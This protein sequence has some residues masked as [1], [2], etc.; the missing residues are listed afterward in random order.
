MQVY[1]QREALSAQKSYRGVDDQDRLDFIRAQKAKLG[2]GLERVLAKS[3]KRMPTNHF[4][5]DDYDYLEFTEIV[6]QRDIAPGTMQPSD[7]QWSIDEFTK[8]M[9]ENQANTMDRIKA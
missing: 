3:N 2:P 8:K 9:R 1:A 6:P 4:L 7:M 5:K